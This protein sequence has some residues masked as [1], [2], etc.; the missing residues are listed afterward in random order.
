[1][2]RQRF[3]DRDFQDEGSERA[4]AL[5]AALAQVCD[6][7]F[8]E[9]LLHHKTALDEFGGQLY[10]A[11]ARH[12]FDSEGKPA[13]HS[14]PGAY[15]TVGYVWHYGHKAQLRGQ[16]TEPDE[17]WG[18]AEA[19]EVEGSEPEGVEEAPEVPVED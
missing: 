17:A 18:S 16:V 19:P 11:A 3:I 5:A 4:L 7:R 8:L 9:T 13:D 10:I 15:E 14:E 1:M 2:N 6:A 12:K